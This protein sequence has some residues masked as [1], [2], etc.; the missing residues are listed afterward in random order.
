MK[1]K[2]QRLRR[3]NAIKMETKVNKCEYEAKLRE[4][5]KYGDHDITI[6]RGKSK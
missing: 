5:R 1:L 3:K 6:D 4:V 2:E